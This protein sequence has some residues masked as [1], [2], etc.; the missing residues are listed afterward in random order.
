MSDD[1]ILVE[2]SF[3]AIINA[4][5]E[6]VDLPDWAFNLTEAEYKGCSPAHIAAGLTRA[7][8]GRRMSIN[9]EMIGGSLSVQH[10][11][12]EVS[13]RDHLILASVSDVLTPTGRTTVHVTWEMNVKAVDGASCEFINRVCVR[14][15]DAFLQFLAQQGVP[16]E[17]FRAMRQPASVA[18]NRDETPMFAA[19]IERAALR[20]IEANANRR[21]A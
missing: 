19:S 3:Q 1:V 15:T 18:H 9:V 12:E 14:P 17:Q 7:E 20:R 8:D 16:F 11:V 13:E 5:V 21:K 10:Y 2:S 6:R 4:P